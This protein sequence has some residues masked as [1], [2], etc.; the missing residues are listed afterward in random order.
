[1]IA[2]MIASDND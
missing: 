1:M 2:T